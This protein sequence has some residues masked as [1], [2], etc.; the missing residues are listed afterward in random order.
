MLVNEHPCINFPVR[1][2]SVP[3]F[4]VPMFH[5]VDLTFPPTVPLEC[6]LEEQVTLRPGIANAVMVSTMTDPTGG[7]TVSINVSSRFAQ[8]LLTTVKDVAGA[9]ITFRANGSTTGTFF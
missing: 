6:L 4:M 2:T 9:L 8:V 3:P 7:L 5:E 1:I